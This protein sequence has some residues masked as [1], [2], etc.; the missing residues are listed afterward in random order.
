MMNTMR[1]S[2]PHPPTLRLRRQNECQPSPSG[3]ESD[4]FFSFL[5]R[6]LGSR[7][8]GL[9][10]SPTVAFALAGLLWLIGGSAFAT[11]GPGVNPL[12][13]ADTSSP[14][15]TLE[16]FLQVMNE[17]YES[18]VGQNGA[19]TRYLRSDRLFPDDAEFERAFAVIS[20]GRTVAGKYLDLGALPA[21]TL[22]QVSWRLTMQ[23][24]EIL[25]RIELPSSAEIPDAAMM[26]SLPFKKWTV[27]GTEI[28]IGLIETGP[29]AGEYVFTQETVR[30]IPAFYERIKDQPDRSHYA[31]ALYDLVF[32]KPSGLGVLFVKF[33]PLR[34]FLTLPAWTESL[35]LDQPLWRWAAMA[36][37]F[38]VQLGIFWACLRIARKMRRGNT[39]TTNAWTLLPTISLLLLTPATN[40]VMSEVL[41]VSPSLYEAMTLA[42]WGLF[43]LALTWLVWVL[44]RLAGDW[45]ISIERLKSDSSDSQL[46]RLA[47]RLIAMV[48][49]LCIL[50]EG[51]N[52]VG[53]PSYSVIAGLGIGGLAAALAGQQALANLFGSLIIMFEKP[54]RIGHS[55]RTVGIEGR[56]EDI[57]FR[58]T[59]LR[60]PENTLMLVPSNELIRHTIENLTARKLWRVKRT[61][62]LSTATPV[63]RL[64]AFRDAVEALLQ[65][66]AD[67]KQDAIQVVLTHIGLTGYELL[68]DFAI[69]APDNAG[70]LRKTDQLLTAIA[71]LA[72]QQQIRFEQGGG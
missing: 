63:A 34:W 39:P 35:I 52:R 25:D 55:I 49:A 48:L 4:G 61:L 29:R 9:G 50:I 64:R 19:V 24:K 43:Y 7:P 45:L 27:P 13:P 14:R 8:L 60:T 28:R 67:I 51:A 15:G 44:G 33:V 38:A 22:E 54:F 30:Q 41:K 71:D 46:I 17:R 70:Q 62:Y 57:G 5:R 56:V 32:H 11:P 18:M 31:Y 66:D 6:R 26:Q 1:H 68:V 47:A 69:R 37:V 72:E 53:L 58:S 2:D 21:A 59:R 65:A 42:L 12:E 16:G 10:R 40:F 20:R 3:R 36:L 23:L